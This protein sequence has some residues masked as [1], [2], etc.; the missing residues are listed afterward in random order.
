MTIPKRGVYAL[1][2]VAGG[3]ALAL[4]RF[5]LSSPALDPESAAAAEEHSASSTA[6][7]SGRA[8]MR[9]EAIPELK[10]PRG[11]P[12][13]DTSALRDWFSPPLD[14]EPADG[15]PGANEAGARQREP[16]GGPSLA[17]LF[18]QRHQLSAVLVRGDM[19]IAV[20][21]DRWCRPGQSLD[22]CV[23]R[24]VS[25]GSAVFECGSEVVVLEVFRHGARTLPQDP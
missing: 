7:L 20:V 24:E 14:E 4:D 8:L 25:D 13:L 10:F 5:V 3:V 15:E 16:L 9:A 11:L 2:L 21:N 19:R 6:A 22:G 12:P 18:R 1:I 17:E 23:L